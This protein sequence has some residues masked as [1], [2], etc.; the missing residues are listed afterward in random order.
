MSQ[1]VFNRRQFLGGGLAA[2]ALC[3]S[4]LTGCGSS[5]DPIVLPPVGSDIPGANMVQ[6]PVLRS[7]DGRLTTTFDISYITTTV[8]TPFG[9]K[10]ASLRTWNGFLGGPTFRVRP[11]DQLVIQINNNLPPNTDPVPPDHNTPHH[12]NTI[13]L[14]THG[15]HVSPD[16]DNVELAIPPGGTY[17]YTYDIPDDHP[18]GT[19]WYHAHKHGATA[20]HLMS[21]MAGL[22]IVEGEVDNDPGVAEA[23][24]LDFVI[25]EIN[26]GMVSDENNPPDQRFEVPDYV[27]PS[28]FAR[29]DSF[30]LVNSEYQ[31]TL[32]V[33]PGRTVR[34]RILNASTRNTMPISI[35][36]AQ[37]TVISFDGI[38]IPE[39]LTVDS[40]RLAPANRVD[41]ILKFED[42]GTF[43][44]QKDE[45]SNNT[46]GRPFPA[47]TLATINVV[48]QAFDFPLPSGSLTTPA[49]LPDITAAEV[50][51]APR[52][53]VYAVGQNGPM[54]GGQQANNFTINGVRFDPQVINET[55]TLNSVIEWTLTNT[56]N[57]WHSHHIHINPFQVIDVSSPDPDV[58]NTLQ[59]LPLTRP[60]WLDTVDIPPMGSVTFRSRYPDFTGLFVQ[61]CHILTHEDIGMMQNVNIVAP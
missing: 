35:P 29:D 27:K 2:A 52:T 56:S 16:Q 40:V 21:G 47:E 59:G 4:V 31:P 9:E 45:F 57:A 24:Q 25:Q 58:N 54:I 11:G 3:S 12:F 20:M 32:T 41:V 23:F 55:I 61:H 17:T 8:N 46:Q 44:I 39:P 13:N 6:P 18:A 28:P 51:E 49:Q 30:F 50:T 37:M 1:R 7:T 60:V 43:T 34:L 42:E 33:N 15:L 38:T 10:T 48:G 53:L 22:I 36:G 19:F 26:F 5:N 14:H